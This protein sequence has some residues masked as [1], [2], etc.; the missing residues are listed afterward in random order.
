MSFF[1]TDGNGLKKSPAP[2]KHSI[3]T[4]LRSTPPEK[5]YLCF[6]FAFPFFAQFLFIKREGRCPYG[7]PKSAPGY[8]FNAISYTNVLIRFSWLHINL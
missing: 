1:V 8:A 5:M 6:H 3:L 4:F 7:P 2:K